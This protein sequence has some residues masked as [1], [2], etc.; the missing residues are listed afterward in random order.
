MSGRKLTNNEIILATKIF[1][2]SIKYRDVSIYHEKYAFF[3]PN[4][5]GMT[6]NG[7]IY[8]DGTIKISD[9]GDLAIAAASRAFYIHE[10][11]HVWQKQ[12]KVLNPLISAVANAI[13]HGFFYQEAYKYKLDTN[14][15]FLDY[16][17]EQQAQIIE[18]YSRLTIFNLQPKPGY[19]SNK[20]TG[21]SLLK[22]FKAVLSK[23]LVDPSYPTK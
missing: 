22:L 13:R 11:V 23:F 21:I 3:Q 10:M 20:E 8:I 5:S 17:I 9:Y 7:N 18:D 19:M 16:R 2:K 1:G 15:D 14:Q 6:P 12:N 4:N